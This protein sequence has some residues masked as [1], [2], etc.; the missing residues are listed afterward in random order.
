MLSRALQASITSG[1]L[2]PKDENRCMS[3]RHFINSSCADVG[4]VHTLGFK[5]RLMRESFSPGD[6]GENSL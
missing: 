6:P 2:H 4:C 5:I 1:G 3:A